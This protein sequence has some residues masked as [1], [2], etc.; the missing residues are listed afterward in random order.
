MTK[1]TL[2]YA[3]NSQERFEAR[4]KLIKRGNR[5]EERKRTLNNIVKLY[6]AEKDN[7][8]LFDYFTTMPSEARY[9]A[10]NTIKREGI[11]ILTP[12]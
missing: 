6:D 2:E 9:T 5:T 7:I 10:T 1:Y 12:K 3:K 8:D 11:K 4:L